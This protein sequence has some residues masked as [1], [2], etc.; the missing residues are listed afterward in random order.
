MYNVLNIEKARVTVIYKLYLCLWWSF[1]DYVVQNE[2]KNKITDQIAVSESH[3]LFQWE[4][5]GGMEDQCA[6]QDE[7]TQQ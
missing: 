7:R 3:L 2:Y 6:A 4:S 5:V 1:D